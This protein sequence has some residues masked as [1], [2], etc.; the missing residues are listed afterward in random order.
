MTTEHE[1]AA[2]GMIFVRDAVRA[3][4]AG[5]DG[6]AELNAATDGQVRWAAGYMLSI[7]RVMALESLGGDERRLELDLKRR[8]DLVDRD[9]ID[10][11][12]AMFARDIERGI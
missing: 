1:D 5:G 8:A 3:M 12:V 10:T 6:L 2:G 4:A 11:Q 9:I 7:I